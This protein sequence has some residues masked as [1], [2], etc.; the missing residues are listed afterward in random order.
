M[1]ERAALRLVLEQGSGHLNDHVLASCGTSMIFVTCADEQWRSL[2][3]SHRGH[4]LAG[5]KSAFPGGLAGD[6]ECGD[7]A[8]RGVDHGRDRGARR[9]GCR[10]RP[11]CGGR[12]PW[13]PARHRLEYLNQAHRARQ[14]VRL[15]ALLGPHHRLTLP[16]TWIWESRILL[17]RGLLA[18][19]VRVV[20]ECRVGDGGA[21]EGALG[22]F[23]L[24]AVMRRRSNCRSRCR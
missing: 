19:G 24:Q 23:L 12:S 15:P 5:D 1:T 22:V 20:D 9:P 4:G 14:S 21:R 3:R 7:D 8:F 6:V 18:P 2:S 17:L 10:R 11:P 16:A 13:S